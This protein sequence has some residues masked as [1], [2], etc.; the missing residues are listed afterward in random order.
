MKGK[1]KLHS[2][3]ARGDEDSFTAVFHSYYGP[4][5]AYITTYTRDRNLAEDIVQASFVIL[6]EKRKKLD[7]HTSLKS[8]LYRTAYNLFADEYKEARKTSDYLEGLR[9]EAL[10]EVDDLGEEELL[11]QVKLLEEAI[12]ELPSKCRKIFEMNKKEGL[13]YKEIAGRLGI[14]VKT[15][16]AQLR[17]AI[18]KIRKKLRGTPR[19]LLLI[20]KR[21]KLFSGVLHAS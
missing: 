8:Y 5:L 10:E 13:S 21:K 2:F 16:E 11:R 4:L 15:V 19:I 7:V 6:W 12:A 17:I 20:L 14:S 1:T 9:K 3:L 18:I